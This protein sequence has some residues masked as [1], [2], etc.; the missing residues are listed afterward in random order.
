MTRTLA[1]RIGKLEAIGKPVVRVPCVLHV[2][3]NETGEEARARFAATYPD[4]LRNH[5]LLVV[6]ARDRGAA[7]DADFDVRFNEQQTKLIAAARSENRKVAQCSD[8]HC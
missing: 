6:P 4:A 3:R 5:R 2:G 8:N 7:D 1:K